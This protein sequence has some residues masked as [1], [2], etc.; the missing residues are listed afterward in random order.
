MFIMPGSMRLY[1]AST[2]TGTLTAN[3]SP[4]PKTKQL[5]K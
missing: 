2:R 1:V 4:L 3:E 5:K